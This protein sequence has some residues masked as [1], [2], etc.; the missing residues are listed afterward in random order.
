MLSVELLKFHVSDAFA[1]SVVFSSVC[2]YVC[3]CRG[4]HRRRCVFFFRCHGVYDK[5]F[6]HEK[7]S[8]QFHKIFPP[9]LKSDD[10]DFAADLQEVSFPD[11]A[12]ESAG[13]NGRRQR[14]LFFF[15]LRCGTFCFP[16]R[17]RLF[18]FGRKVLTGQ[19]FLASKKIIR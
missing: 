16:V 13:E 10:G 1:I 9:N 11:A 5:P 4:P 18:L 19:S 7:N 8:S 12:R 2:V 14:R 17:C 15:V 6:R 3:L